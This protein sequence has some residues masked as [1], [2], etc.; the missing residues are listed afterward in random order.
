MTKDNYPGNGSPMPVAIVSKSALMRKRV[1]NLLSD[2]NLEV[3]EL[4]GPKAFLKHPRQRPFLVCF[5]DTRGLGGEKLKDS[6]KKSRPGERYVFI[7]DAWNFSDGDGGSSTAFGCLCEAFGPA[8]LAVITQRALDEER[9]ADSAPP[10]E[11]LLYQRFRDFLH[12]LGP[13]SM[14]DLHSLINERVERPLLLAVMEWSRGNQTKASE[15]LGIH[16][17][18]LRTKLK[19]LGV[20]SRLGRSQDE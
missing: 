18:T 15:I 8:E 9:Q 20:D 7:R 17:N 5:V 16:R 10:L 4:N 2:S 13:A 6:F 12:N 14:K 3:V 11:D 19:T 1:G